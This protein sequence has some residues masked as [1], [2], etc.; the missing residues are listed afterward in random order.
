[1]QYL[2][3]R[4]GG[5]TLRGLAFDEKFRSGEWDFASGPSSELVQIVERYAQGGDI[6]MLGCGTASIAGALQSDRFATFLGVDL[7]RE[8]ITRASQH[9]NHRIRFQVGNMV[10]FVSDRKYQVILFSEALYYA[11]CWQRRP[12]L[13]R[14]TRMLTPQGHIIVTIA[15]P[16]RFAG[17]LRMMRRHFEVAED[18][19]FVGSPRH[20]MVVR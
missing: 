7:S 15:Q 5:P 14:A 9:S 11:H 17:I 10:R 4:F 8:A 19:A 1:V 18:R 3:T 2:V 12:L 16:E 13:V 6:L 20:L